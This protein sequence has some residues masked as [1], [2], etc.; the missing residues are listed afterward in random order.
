[1]WTR[2]PVYTRARI[3]MQIRFCVPLIYYIS[4]RESGDLVLSTEMQLF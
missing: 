3:I 2:V 4:T 1:M